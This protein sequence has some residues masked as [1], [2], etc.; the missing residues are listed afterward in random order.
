MNVPI[1]LDLH[2][3]SRY[4]VDSSLSLDDI[5]ELAGTAG[6]QGFALTDHDTVRGHAELARLRAAHPSY[7]L[8]PGVEVST[9]EGHLLVYGVSD[10]PPKGR[11]LAETLDWVRARS[12]VAVLAHPF[13]WS[14]GVGRRVAS[15]AAVD[16]LEGQNGR[17]SELANSQASLLAAKRGL[18]VTGGSDAHGPHAVGRAYT[19][20][21]D[22]VTG[23]EELLDQ[24]RH[25]H[26]SGEGASLPF[27][28]RVVVSLRNGFQRAFRGFRPVGPRST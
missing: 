21:R 14:H 6:L 16:G 5:L 7:W 15:R 11:P 24:I 12:G 27:G 19:E 17:N 2:V 4:S 22:P 1:R 3:H 8:I 10:L 28:A 26:T 9:Q 18:S 25:G 13:R 23:V 20:F